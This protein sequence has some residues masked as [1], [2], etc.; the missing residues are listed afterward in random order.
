MPLDPHRARTEDLRALV[1]KPKLYVPR[2]GWPAVFV[3]LAGDRAELRTSDGTPNVT[4]I[5]TIA[6]L[7]RSHLTQI[8]N[9]QLGIGKKVMG[10][11]VGFLM[12]IHGYSR[13]EAEGAL[14][15]LVDEG[16]P[17]AARP[18]AVIAA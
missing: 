1:L 9:F 8:K 17:A 16:D 7:D 15:D 14:W 4:L 5:S 11:L 13:E 2:G 6:G 3:L 10:A 12:T 18:Q